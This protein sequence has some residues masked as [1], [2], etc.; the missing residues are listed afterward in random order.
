M[1][2]LLH[3]LLYAV[4]YAAAGTAILGLGY[5]VLDLVTPGRLGHVLHGIKADYEHEPDVVEASYSAAVVAAAW[6]L[7]NALVVFSAIWFNGDADLGQA[8]L[9][10]LSFG[11]VGVALNAL[12]LFVLDLVTP[13]NLREIITTPGK[14]VPLAYAAAAVPLALSLIVFASTAG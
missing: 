12:L 4:I 5:Y 8:F 13:G 9:W 2:D 11:I 3:A 1:N 7:G 6:L 10:T 14:V